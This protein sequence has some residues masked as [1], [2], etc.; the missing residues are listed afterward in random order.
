MGQGSGRHSQAIAYNAAS[1]TST[2]P[3]FDGNGNI[4]AMVEEQQRS[5]VQ[6]AA[7]LA[8]AAQEHALDLKGGTQR[9]FRLAA[10]IP[11]IFVN[12]LMRRGIWQDTKRLMQWI[13]E[14]APRD[15]RAYAGRLR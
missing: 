3:I 2:T 9:H 4:V 13:E 15:F 7:T 6:E 12:D 5:A 11:N 10:E 14:E 8:K 1:K